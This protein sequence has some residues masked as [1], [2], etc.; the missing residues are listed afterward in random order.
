MIRGKNPMHY[1][2]YR[3]DVLQSNGTFRRVQRWVPLGFV[4]EMSVRAAWKALQPYLDR[5]NQANQS[6]PK[7]GITLADFLQE[8]RANVAANL[9]GSTVRAVESHFRAHIFAKTGQSAPDKYNHESS[10]KLRGLS[11]QWRTFQKNS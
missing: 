4:S 8:R 5:V 7:T 2:I 9:K 6:K 10:A 11:S 3:E 1:G